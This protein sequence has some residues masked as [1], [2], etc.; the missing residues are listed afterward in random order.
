MTNN[1]KQQILKLLFSEILTVPRAQRLLA[2]EK[3]SS[4]RIW[5]DDDGNPDPYVAML[6]DEEAEE[7][8]RRTNEAGDWSDWT[9]ELF[10]RLFGIKMELDLDLLGIP[11]RTRRDGLFS[12]LE[13]SD[14]HDYARTWLKSKGHDV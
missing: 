1:T 3:F 11:P 2:T 10:D 6:T 5:Y 4:Q 8:A 14:I 7:F 12:R 13:T 9:D